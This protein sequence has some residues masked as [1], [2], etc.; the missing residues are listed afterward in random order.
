VTAELNI[1]PE[2]PVTTKKF[3]QELHKSDIHGTAATS[4]P[5][6]TDSSAKGQKRWCDDHK[7]WTSDDWKYVIWSDELSFMLFPTSGWSM[8]GYHPRKPITP[9]V[10]FQL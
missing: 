7:T 8:F 3:Q 2:E 1:H 9:N 4:K 10:W 6:I 5:L